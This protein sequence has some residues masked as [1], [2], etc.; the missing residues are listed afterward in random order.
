MR[1]PIDFSGRER[2]ASDPAT[3]LQDITPS[4]TA[5]LPWATNDLTCLVEGHARVT[6]TGGTTSTVNLVPGVAMPVAATRVLSTG[7]T[8]TGIVE[9]A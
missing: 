7:T 4:D 3:H 9:M 8:A 6:T 1:A 2:R 5:D